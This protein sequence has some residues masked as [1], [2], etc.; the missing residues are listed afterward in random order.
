M[1]WT[2]KQLREF[3]ERKTKEEQEKY[4]SYEEWKESIIP[5]ID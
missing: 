1:R 2:E 4:G 3:W 5:E